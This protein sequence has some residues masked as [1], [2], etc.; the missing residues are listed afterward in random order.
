MNCASETSERAIAI[1]TYST[2]YWKKLMCH[3]MV[4]SSSSGDV[5]VLHKVK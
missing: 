4:K 2:A 1:H 3:E 5:S